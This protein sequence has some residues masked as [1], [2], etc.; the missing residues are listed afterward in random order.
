MWDFLTLLFSALVIVFVIS[1]AVRSARRNR[2]RE[3]GR[4]RENLREWQDVIVLFMER[5]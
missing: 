4:E 5:R 2:L 1:S 3:L